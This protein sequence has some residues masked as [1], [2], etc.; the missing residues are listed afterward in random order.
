MLAVSPE[1]RLRDNAMTRSKI[2]KICS[3]ALAL[4]VLCSLFCACGGEKEVKNIPET[5]DNYRTFYQIFPYSFADSNGDGIG[6]IQGIIDKLD[7]IDGMHFDGIWLTPVHQSPSYHKYDV[8]DYKSIDIKFGTLEDYDRLVEECHNRG[9]TILLDL[10]FNHTALDNEWFEMSYGAH[11]RNR[12]DNRYYNYYNWSDREVKPNVWHEYDGLYYEG[13]FW[14]GMPDLNLQYVLD[15]PEGYLAQDLKEIMRFWLID[16]NV[17]GFRLDAVTSYF[18]ANTD[19]N[20]EFLTWLNDTA[21]SIKPNCYIVGEG[22][23]GNTQENT[24]YQGSGVDSFFAFEHGYAGDHSISRATRLGYGADWSDIDRATQKSVA[25]G[26]PALF[27]SNHDTA[28]AYGILQGAVNVNY[29]K[30][31][32]G[33]MAMCCGCTYWYYGDEVGMAV[34]KRPSDKDYIDEMKRQPM[35][36]GDSYT[37]NP[38]RGSL[39]T[40]TDSDKYPLGTVAEN[41]KNEDS[42]LNYITRANALRRAFP[43]IARSYGEEVFWEGSVAIVKKGSGDDVIYIAVNVSANSTETVDLAQELGGKFTLAGTLSAKDIATLKKDL[44]TLPSQSIAVIKPAK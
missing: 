42:V 16:H 32:Y 20:K 7:Y 30:M 36:W 34:Y 14:D 8:V 19:K 29:L 10:V 41:L 4:T 1:A 9:M 25:G 21:K 28:R 6:D 38:V 35:P 17:D 3:L 15:E 24:K 5:T 33:L 22:A 23:W 43:Q 2:I 11:V 26:I 39:P 12:K 27:V 18:S 40:A 31:G 13:Q 37:C 44:L